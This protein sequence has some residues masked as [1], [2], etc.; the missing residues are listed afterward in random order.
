MSNL[1]T[2]QSRIIHAI[3]L[4]EGQRVAYILEPYYKG[5]G[6]F[7]LNA[8]FVEILKGSPELVHDSSML[9]SYA[10]I[11]ADFRNRKVQAEA[12]ILVQDMSDEQKDKF[13]Q[14]YFDAANERQKAFIGRQ[15]TDEVVKDVYAAWAD[16]QPPEDTDANSLPQDVIDALRA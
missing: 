7:D 16:D 8:F 15:S 6:V 11:A 14:Q 10:E 9:K 3:Q 4:P 2:L 5:E 1:T 12:S 13:G